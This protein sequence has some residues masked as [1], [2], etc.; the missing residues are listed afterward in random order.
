MTSNLNE[1]PFKGLPFKTFPSD[2]NWI[3]IGGSPVGEIQV[4]KFGSAGLNEYL[5]YCN[6]VALIEGDSSLSPEQK[7]VRYRLAQVTALLIRLDPTWTLKKTQ[8]PWECQASD[9]ST[10]TFIPSMA[11]IEALGDFFVNEL[12]RWEPTDYVLRIEHQIIPEA[13]KLAIAQAKQQRL[14]VMTRT[15]L[16]R[17]GIFLLYRR[18]HVPKSQPDDPLQWVLVA[19]HGGAEGFAKEES[20]PSKK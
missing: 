13:K 9:G 18:R 20:R 14:V 17:S 2:S 10:Q 1:R 5:F 12:N 15:D 8:S 19:D 3:T 16:E 6:Q 7:S 11:L 4:P